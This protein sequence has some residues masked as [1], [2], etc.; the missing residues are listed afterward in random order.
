MK[1][2]KILVISGSRA[3]Y[4]ILRPLLRKITSDREL[5]L[6]LVITG[7]HLS[8]QHG[9]TEDEIK[10]DKFPIYDRVEMQLSSDSKNGMVKST[11]LGM[12]GFSDLF[13]RIVPDMMVCL[14]DRY[15]VFA[16]VYAASLMQIP[17]AHI[18]GGE[19]TFGAV[20]EFIRHSI[21]K[22]STIHFA[23]TQTY[24]KRIIQMGESPKHVFNVGALSV[25]SILERRKISITEMQKLI[26]NKINNNY[27]LITIHPP[28]SQKINLKKF[29]NEILDALSNYNNVTLIFT[30]ANS[31]SGGYII[32][33]MC[34][35]FCNLD[36][37]KRIIKKSLGH[38][39]Y[40]N[41]MR[42]AA[43]VIGNSSS[44]VIEA[45]IVKTP[46]VNIGNRQEGRYI[47][48]SVINTY[49]IKENIITAINKALMIEIAKNNL[50]PF[51]NGKTSLKIIKEIKYFIKS[52]KNTTKI[53]ND[54]DF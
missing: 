7:S 52:G 28:T 24:K 2:Y 12:I 8:P 22:F 30:N 5:K 26:K 49:P 1:K 29:T 40:I 31:D 17:I 34:E 18:H 20:D 27:F 21:T 14:G 41:L 36:P 39:L 3:E 11:A 45:P 10:K 6:Y 51:G 54:I 44:G 9:K 16:G 13:T 4:G 53:F 32:N 19:T 33:K 25:E 43:L 37:E 15:E 50:H 47:S 42:K 46:T 23:T 48:E 35:N 38:E